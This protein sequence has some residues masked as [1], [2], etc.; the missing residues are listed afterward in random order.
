[1]KYINKERPNEIPEI[2][3]EVATCPLCGA[4]L[5]IED[6]DEWELAT[7]RVT[8]AGL[9]ITCSTQ[10][11]PDDTDFCNWWNWHYQTPYVDWLPI[12]QRVYGWFDSRYRVGRKWE[13]YSLIP[14]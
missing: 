12:C 8:E 3:T 7:G 13:K 10:P 2:P 14:E 4:K 9:H 6:I 1:M 5:V 11:E